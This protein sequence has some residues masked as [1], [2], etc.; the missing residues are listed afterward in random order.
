MLSRSISGG[1]DNKTKRNINHQMKIEHTKLQKLAYD[2]LCAKGVGPEEGKI[3]AK[4]LVWCNLVGRHTQGVIRLPIL[5]KRFSLDLI[6]SPSHPE[7]I[8]KSETMY[9]LAGNDGFGQYLGH[10]AMS[11]AIETAEKFGMGMVG[12]N[13]SNHFGANAYYV[14]MA[15]QSSK[16][17][18]AFSNGYPRTAPHGGISATLGTNPLG[19]S[20]PMKNEQSILVDLATGAS[21]GSIIR[22]AISEKTKIPEGVLIDDRGNSIVDPHQAKDGG[23][24]LP[25]GGAKGFCLGLMVE[26]LSG[27]ITGAAISH[28]VASMYKNFEQSSHSGHLFIAI[29]IFR[30][31]ERDTYYQKMSDLIS[32]IKG[33][34]IQNGFDE[35]LLPGEARWRNYE[36]QLADGIELESETIKILDDLAKKS[37]V[38][39]PWQYASYE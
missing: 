21:S 26:I 33:A 3:L 20:A 18:L 23:T 28:E 22:Q 2:I 31:I 11:K 35:I 17:G 24:I 14:Q 8:K 6:K 10:V 30:M 13:G 1:K 34:K 37:E 29:D 12:V 15:A 5:L 9:L 36:R 19:F 16:I 32:F 4:A 7:L 25:F 38:A 27:V 39:T